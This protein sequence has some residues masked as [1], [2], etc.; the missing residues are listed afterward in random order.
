MTCFSSRELLFIVLSAGIVK[1]LI[2]YSYQDKCFAYIYLI[3][4]LRS[5]ILLET[6]TLFIFVESASHKCTISPF[7]TTYSDRNRYRQIIAS[8][9]PLLS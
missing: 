9:L 5:S 7:R 1:H 6:A 3:P 2:C 4:H 8:D